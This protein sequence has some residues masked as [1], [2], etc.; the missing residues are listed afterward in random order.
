MVDDRMIYVQTGEV[1]ASIGDVTL[2]SSAI[3]S[4]VVVAAYDCRKKIGALAHIMLPGKAPDNKMY[5]K[6]RFAVDA[7]DVMMNDLY[8]LGA[9]VSDI[10]VCLVGGANVLKREKDTIGKVNIKSVLQILRDMN[11]PIKGESLGGVERRSLSLHTE[12]GVVYYTIGDG[13]REVLYKF[14]VDLK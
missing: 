12:D 4:C 6:K 7:I 10:E 9:N 11:L 2:K 1:E 8:S 13:A 14:C 3:G 5:E